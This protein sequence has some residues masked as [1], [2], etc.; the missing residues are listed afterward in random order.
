[1]QLGVI[2]SSSPRRHFQITTLDVF[3]LRDFFG[4]QCLSNSMLLP[5]RFLLLYLTFFSLRSKNLNKRTPEN[6]QL[7]PRSCLTT[8]VIYLFDQRSNVILIILTKTSVFHHRRR[9]EKQVAYLST[10]TVDHRLELLFCNCSYEAYQ[11]H[12]AWDILQAA[13]ECNTSNGFRNY[14]CFCCSGQFCCF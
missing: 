14:F 8:S 11:W 2:L 5:N 3:S 1:M 13:H 9:K 12:E 6:T 4:F 10:C 7:L